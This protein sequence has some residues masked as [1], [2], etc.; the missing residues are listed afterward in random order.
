MS[1][2]QETVQFPYVSEQWADTGG[3][4]R[5]GGCGSENPGVVG[6]IPSPP[7]FSYG[8]C[9][10]FGP[11]EGRFIAPP[12]LNITFVDV[13]APRGDL[14]RVRDTQSPHRSQR[15]DWR[16]QRVPRSV[17]LSNRKARRTRPCVRCA[18]G[19]PGKSS[20]SVL[21]KRR[22]ALFLTTPVLSTPSGR[23][24]FLMSRDP[25]HEVVNR[26][27]EFLWRTDHDSA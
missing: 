2:C 11:A 8:P 9:P 18:S 10:A 22:D 13:M 14:R 6:S 12:F 5:N 4:G 3:H 19:F 21:V 23:N 25:Y 7:I 15:H 16:S 24:L 17:R 20:T 26:S 27:R 1:S